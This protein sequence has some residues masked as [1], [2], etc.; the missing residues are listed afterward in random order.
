M[1]EYS[2]RRELDEDVL[3]IKQERDMYLD[4]VGSLQ[5]QKKQQD[6][7]ESKAAATQ[8]QLYRQLN[9]SEDRNRTLEDA[10]R[11]LNTEIEKLKKGDEKTKQIQEMHEYVEEVEEKLHLA[12]RDLEE[13]RQENL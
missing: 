5:N 8:T 4:Q 10:N 6:V 12:E 9:E 3:K 2:T 11:K 1:S 7:D 13:F